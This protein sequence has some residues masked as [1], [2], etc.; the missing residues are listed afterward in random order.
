MN[1]MSRIAALPLAWAA[2]ALP[3]AAAM[4][5]EN[6]TPRQVAEAYDDNTRHPTLAVTFKLE[7]CR[8]T[9][10]QSQMRCVERPRQ[11][12]VENILKSYG[13]D[14]RSVAI[15]SEPISDRG[16]GMLAF[17]YWDKNKINDY[18]MYLPALNKVK[19]VVSNRDAKD[20]GSYFGTEFYLEDLEDPRLD[21]YTFRLLPNEDLQVIEQDKVKS[22]PAYVLEWLPTLKR[23]ENSNYSKT[24]MWVDRSRF[25][26]LKAEYYDQQG[27]LIKRRT[28]RNLDKVNGRW[29]PR[30]NLMDN[31]VDQRITVMTREAAAIG[32][33]VG[34]EYF[35]QRTLTDEVFREKFLNQL[36]NSL[37]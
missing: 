10:Q 13:R 6:M 7:S 1:I 18:W 36:R 19:R 24:V 15:L 32:V 37:K 4:A 5:E 14:I 2:L 25:V 17:E 21:D 16:I 23:K 28:V 27:K 11:R 8:Y 3:M 31:L 34:D 20:S 26:L 29:M 12:V 22:V 30:Q 33:E 9:I 35:T